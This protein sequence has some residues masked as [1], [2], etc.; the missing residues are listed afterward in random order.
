MGSTSSEKLVAAFFFNPFSTTELNYI[1]FCTINMHQILR[2]VLASNKGSIRVMILIIILGQPRL[3][4]S[5][6][7]F[8]FKRSHVHVD[9]SVCS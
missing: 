6:L 7:F 1:I 9:S 2:N 5:S 3:P 8:K 4:Y